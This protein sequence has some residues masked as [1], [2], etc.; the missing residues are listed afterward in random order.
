MTLAGLL[1]SGPDELRQSV[2]GDLLWEAWIKIVEDLKTLQNV[3]FKLLGHRSAQTCAS[4]Q[5]C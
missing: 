1:M 3:L 4:W 5:S 2:S